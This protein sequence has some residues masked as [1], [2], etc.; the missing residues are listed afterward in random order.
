MSWSCPHCETSFGRKDSMKRHINNRHSNLDHFTP[1][2]AMPYS[3]EKCQ[4]FQFE[5]P[6]TCMV[7]GMTGSGKTVW[8]QSLLTQAYRMINLPPERVVWCYSQW[9]PAY[10][11]MLVTIPNI[12]FVKGIP[13]ALE[14]DAYFNVNKRNLI[15]FDDQMIDAGKDKRIV[16]LFTRGS[17]HRNLSVI[18]IV[19]NLFHQGK[20]S[21]SISLNS[22]YLVLFKN[23]RDKLQVLTLAKQM[24]PGRTEFFLRQYE[25]AVR[26]P[27]GYLLID[28]KTTTQDD[29]RLRTN[30]LP[31]EERFNQVEV[32]GNIP[33]ELLRY[34]KQQNL[35]TDPHLPAMQRLQSG[36]DSTLSRSDLGEDEKAKQFLQ[37]QNRYLTFKQQ[38]NTYTPPP[39]RN[40]PEGMNTS[41][42]EVNLP[43][44]T[45]DASR[46]TALSTPLNPF[47]VAPNLNEATVLQGSEPDAP[48]PLNPAILTPPPTVKTPSPLPSPPKRKRQRLHFVNYLDD[49]ESTQK[50]R[51][52]RLKSQSR[53]YKYGKPGGKS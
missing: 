11:D 18:Y 29:C 8:V 53:P 35:S 36:M 17:H 39:A 52:R 45:G 33:Q 20:G 32:E 1:F 48:T 31:G 6:F 24:Y 46:V 14:Q 7:V 50:R 3:T 37:L 22:H 42:P 38:L 16:N 4:R 12:E 47:N 19:Q 40:R 51:S 28:L 21:R 44:S 49:D 13:T 25:E 15:V 30:V 34:L 41:Q 27:Y 26:R 10:M 23:P 5:H 9:Q 43:T 2:N